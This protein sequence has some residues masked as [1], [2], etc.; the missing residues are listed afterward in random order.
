MMIWNTKEFSWIWNDFCSKNINATIK[1]F[2]G[3]QDYLNT[4]L[5]DTNRRFIDSE[6]I[7][8][9]RW[10]CKDGGMDMKSRLYRNPDA[11]TLID[12]KTAVMIFH[13]KPKPHDI[14]DPVI[15]MLW[16]SIIN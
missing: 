14:V 11:G 9:W 7:K 13:G 6:V 3:D 1:Q 12:P 5:I 10:Q 4:V 2:H 8:S 16:K 15:D